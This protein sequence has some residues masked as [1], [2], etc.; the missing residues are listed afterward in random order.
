MQDMGLS[1]NYYRS[2]QHSLHLGEWTGWYYHTEGYSKTFNTTGYGTG[3]LIFSLRSSRW[4]DF[5]VDVNGTTYFKADAPLS[6][7][8]WYQFT[9]P[10]PTGVNQFTMWIAGYLDAYLDDVYL[11]AK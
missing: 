7:N 1:T 5:R 3:I 11:I 2:F 9:I 10:L 6:A 4:D 8:T